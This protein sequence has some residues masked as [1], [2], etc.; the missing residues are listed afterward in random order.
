MVSSII[1]NSNISNDSDNI[2]SSS[3]N[4]LKNLSSN[5]TIVK[6]YSDFGSD[7]DKMIF[8]NNNLGSYIDSLQNIKTDYT[9]PVTGEKEDSSQTIDS[10]QAGR[11]KSEIS[12]YVKNYNST[13]DSANG[14]NNSDISKEL[15]SVT[16]SDNLK[17]IGIKKNTDGTL[18]FDEA[19]YDATV[20][21][22]ST[23]LSEMKN[24][25]TDLEKVYTTTAS[26]I[27]SV[28]DEI[29]KVYDNAKTQIS[30]IQTNFNDSQRQILTDAMK[31]L[32]NT[33]TANNFLTSL[34]IGR[35]LNELL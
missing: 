11:L 31:S 14:L 21:A 15:K 23:E 20:K 12:K 35:N 26:S 9:N 7:I 28:N 13:L 25:L 32:F 24:T 1:N 29:D 10:L 4:N 18:S 30:D 16:I 33:S 34:G 5:L 2:E 27:S 22:D 6:N 19:A 17:N 8:A 3:I